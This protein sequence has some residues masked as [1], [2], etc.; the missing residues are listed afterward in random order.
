MGAF[1]L[2]STRVFNNKSPIQLLRPS[3]IGLVI[4]VVPIPTLSD[5]VSDRSETWM[6]LTELEVS[7]FR[8][9]TSVIR[10]SFC[11]TSMQNVV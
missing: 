2:C 5:C 7:R 4:H 1:I 3:H 6:V 11:S 8:D 10:F 9:L